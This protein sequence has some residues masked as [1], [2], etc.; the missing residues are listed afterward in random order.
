MHSALKPKSLVRCT[1][2][3]QKCL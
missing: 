2:A 1:L 3:K